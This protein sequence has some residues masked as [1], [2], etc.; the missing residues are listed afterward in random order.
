MV[1]LANFFTEDLVKGVKIPKTSACQRRAHANHC[2]W[3]K[4]HPR[5]SSLKVTEWGQ[6]VGGAF[7]V[8]QVRHSQPRL[9][10]GTSHHI[11]TV[12]LRQCDHKFDSHDRE[13]SQTDGACVSVNREYSSLFL[14]CGPPLAT[15]NYRRLGSKEGLHKEVPV[16]PVVYS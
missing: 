9:C 16:V 7:L 14:E 4:A 15:E 5:V 1:V 3:Q 13:C 11:P 2:A 12:L 8:T 6:M 10:I